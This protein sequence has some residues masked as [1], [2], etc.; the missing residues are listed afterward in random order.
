MS[1]IPLLKI[2]VLN[3]WILMLYPLIHPIL[4][5]LIVKDAMQKMQAA[6]R[7][8]A[9]KLIFIINSII[10]FFGLFIFSIFLPL[11]LGTAWFYIGL[12]LC[13]LGIIGWTAAIINIAKIPLDKPWVK[14]LY[15]YSRHPMILS[16][17]LIFIGTGIATASWIFLL[18][19]IIFIA[20]S[21]I[22]ANYE[23]RHCLNKFCDAYRDYMNRTP[24]WIGIPRS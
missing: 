16:G 19:A 22:A 15:R 23:E 13:I 4:I 10:L 5:M 12:A 20:F 7:S 6:D 17:F 9:E 2:G 21:I 8:K 24:K 18:F 1:L 3:G 14:G 11:K